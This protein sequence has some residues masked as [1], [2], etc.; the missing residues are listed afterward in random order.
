MIFIVRLQFSID[1]S[2]FIIVQERSPR[3]A[4]KSP[5]LSYLTDMKASRPLDVDV[6]SFSEKKRGRERATH[7]QSFLFIKERRWLKPTPVV[8]NGFRCVSWRPFRV[9]LTPSMIIGSREWTSVDSV[10]TERRERFQRMRGDSCPIQF[11]IHSMGRIIQYYGDE[12]LP[13]LSDPNAEHRIERTNA[14]TPF[15]N[16]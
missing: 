12:W 8:G 5:T 16:V 1:S 13:K 2:M 4:F 15:P 3:S 10:G 6:T 14:S 9:L 7:T 11:L